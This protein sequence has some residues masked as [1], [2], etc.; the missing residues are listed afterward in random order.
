MWNHHWDPNGGG[1]G[2]AVIQME[3]LGWERERVMAMVEVGWGN[4]GAFMD[5]WSKK[6]GA[7]M[8]TWSKKLGAFM[9]TWSK[10]RRPRKLFS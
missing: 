8:D 3:K 4:L 1:S 10:K 7:F 9:D 2:K 5:T 6:L